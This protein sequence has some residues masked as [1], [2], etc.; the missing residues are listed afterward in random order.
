MPA[1][2]VALLLAQAVPAA[3]KGNKPAKAPAKPPAAQPEVTDDEHAVEGIPLGSKKVREQLKIVRDETDDYE[4]GHIA[5]TKVLSDPQAD[6]S[7][8][9]ARKPLP[10]MPYA[11]GR[12]AA[13]RPGN[14]V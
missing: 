14:L 6:I 3:A 12:S 4:P 10:L 1:L 13:L 11:I 9:K 5:L 8:L 7:V 2:L